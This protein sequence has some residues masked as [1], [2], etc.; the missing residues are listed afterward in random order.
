VL[1]PAD[2]RFDPPELAPDEAARIAEDLYGLAGQT[3]RLRGERSHNTR[4][5]TDHG[6]FV[7]R[8]ASASEP[9]AAIE[10]HAGAMVHIERRSPSLPVARV[11]AARDGRLVP[12]IERHGRRH[13]VRLETFLPGVTFDD[14]QAVS[15]PA[16]RQIGELLGGVAAALADFEHHAAHGFMPWDVANG[17]VLDPAL[18][19][20]LST[21][22]TDLVE[23]AAPRLV[24]ATRAMAVLPRQIIHND[25]HA[26]NL[27]RTDGTSEAVTGVID[28]GDLV[29]TVTIADIAVSGA[30]FAPHQRDP[31]GAL[32]ALATGYDARRPLLP[33]E[34]RAIP[35][36]VLTR[37]VLS[38]LLVEYQIA[39]APHIAEAVSQERAGTLANLARWLEIPPVAAAARIE[40]A[41]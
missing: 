38:T 28:F 40:E 30:S 19:V 27:L 15:A 9:D 41:L 3:Q 4:F 22:A 16:L 1:T 10:C 25:G 23:C 8:V 13:R 11:I 36:L 12:A 32:A 17:L 35:D 29:H 14:Q 24:D 31:A 34:V 21:E 33:A 6:E 26:G 2:L 7:L 37:L 18:R 5:V 20:G 39:N